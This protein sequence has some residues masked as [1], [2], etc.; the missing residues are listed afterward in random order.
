MI[1]V[2]QTGLSDHYVR[3]C[4]QR[5][6]VS[7]TL[8]DADLVELRRIRRLQDLG[9]NL[10]GIEVILRMRRRIR[11]LQAHVGRLERRWE[12]PGWLAL[13]DLDANPT[14][15]PHWSDDDR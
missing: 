8:T 4:I 14:R 15:D 6:L 10:P 2:Q 11:A 1:I 13:E 7:E 12:M 9:V 5:S 3:E